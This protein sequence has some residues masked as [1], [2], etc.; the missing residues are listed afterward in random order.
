MDESDRVWT[1]FNDSGTSRTSGN[2]N[3]VGNQ[4]PSGSHVSNFTSLSSP[5]TSSNPFRLTADTSFDE[6]NFA[7]TN[8]MVD[9]GVQDYYYP[10]RMGEK[11]QGGS[12]L[13]LPERVSFSRKNY[14]QRGRWSRMYNTLNGGIIDADSR[15]TNAINGNQIS[16]NNNNTASNGRSENNYENIMDSHRGIPYSDPASAAASADITTDF[17]PAAA[18]SGDDG[19]A[20]FN[21]PNLK[22]NHRTATI[23]PF[24]GMQVGMFTIG[25]GGGGRG[26]QESAATIVVEEA[27]GGVGGRGGFFQ[28]ERRGVG[29]GVL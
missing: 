27:G 12:G 15:R 14:N 9:L 25:G 26:E 8:F 5:P 7:D 10:S 29:G 1:L 4:L 21:D 23:N 17:N 18:T 24:R 28:T 20:D 2:N 13:G 3:G 16:N 19:S 6:V 11:E 22:K